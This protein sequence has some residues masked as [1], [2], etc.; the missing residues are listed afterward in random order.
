MMALMLMLASQLWA[1]T[2]LVQ[3]YERA[4]SLLVLG[5]DKC[6]HVPV[7]LEE[8]A[9][10]LHFEVRCSNDGPW[11]PWLAGTPACVDEYE[12]EE[13]G[14]P[15][16]FVPP[17]EHWFFCGADGRG[18]CYRVPWQTFERPEEVG[19]VWGEWRLSDGA[20]HVVVEFVGVWAVNLDEF[21]RILDLRKE[22]DLARTDP[23]CLE[24]DGH[25]CW[26][27]YEV[28]AQLQDFRSK[29]CPAI[30]DSATQPRPK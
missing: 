16:L 7:G 20:G 15:F 19:P 10:T 6:V 14:S 30:E 11:R 4:E 21:V 25:T 24:R 28:W 5:A 12:A 3:R 8:R 13:S 9:C 2:P 1:G 29:A 27:A 23:A 18:C 26:T 17:H 22:Y